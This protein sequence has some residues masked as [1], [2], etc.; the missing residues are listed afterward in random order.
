MRPRYLELEGLQSFREVQS[1][2]FDKLGEVGLFGIFGPTG[3]GK[4]TIL[5][6]LTLALYGNVQRA[7]RG[8]QGI[9]NMA[10]TMIRVSFTF[11]LV[12]EKI[13][14]TYKVERQYKRKKDSDSSIESK[15]ARLIEVNPAGD[16][17]LADKLGDVNE[18][19]VELIGL[20]F[21]DFTRSVVLPQNKFQ[22]FLLSP[23]GDKTKMLERIFYLEEYGRDLTEKV[24]RKLYRLRNKLS[25]IE[26]ALSML[27]EI[28]E[29]SLR[30][31]KHSVE[32]AA[33][34]KMKVDEALKSSE[35]E[36]GE[37]KEVWE[38]TAERQEAEVKLEGLLER[39]PEMESL[40]SKH[41]SALAAQSLGDRISDLEK[42][43]A[44]L[45]ATEQELQQLMQTLEG[46]R[47]QLEKSE[48]ELK[49]AKAERQERVPK[50]IE[51]RTKL[52]KA[53]ETKRELE[54]MEK[55]LQRLRAEYVMIKRQVDQWEEQIAGYKSR[56]EESLKASET[57]KL[58][59]T[60]L[61]V[62]TGYRDKVQKA[63]VL[64]EE[65]IRA[66][67]TI[68]QQ[69]ARFN[70]LSADIGNQEQ[71]LSK[72][73]GA[74]RGLYEAL[75][76]AGAAY[77]EHKASNR[78]D[79]NDILKAETRYYGIKAVTDSMRQKRKDV[80]L[81][82]A[83]MPDYDRQL[84]SLKKKLEELE[85]K[86]AGKQSELDRA[87]LFLEEKRRAAD[88]GSAAILAQSL[89][90]KEPCPVCGSTSHPSPA[91]HR[92]DED[93]N[94][95]QNSLKEAEASIGSL[96]S[97][98]RTLEREGIK[99][100][101]QHNNLTDQ[102]NQLEA[103]IK[104]KQQE[105]VE[106]SDRLPE[107]Y[108]EL[109]IALLE[110]K[111]DIMSGEKQE[112]LKGVE[113]WEAILAVL[114][115][116][117]RK[118]VEEYN[119]YKVE[120]SGKTSQVE[121]GRKHLEEQKNSCLA[122]EEEYTGKRR[123]Y[124]DIISAMG[125]KSAK[126]ELE[127]LKEDDLKAE[128][129]Y[130]RLQSDEK[131]ISELRREIE[132]SEEAN[133]LE[134]DKLS[135]NTAE[136]RGYKYRKEEK[137]KEIAELLGGLDIELERDKTDKALEALERSEQDA[138]EHLNIIREKYEKAVKDKTVQE[139]Q[140]EIYREKLG[141]DM[142]RLEKELALKGFADVDEVRQAY[143][144][145]D[146]LLEQEQAIKEYE[147]ALSNIK[148]HA[149]VVEKKLRGRSITEEHWAEINSRYQ[150][151][152]AEKESCIGL[153]ENAKSRYETIRVNYESWLSLNGEHKLHTRK[154][155]HLELFKNLL[156]GNGFIEYISEER[157]RYV[158]REASETLGTLTRHRYG[159][160][161]DTEN[162]FVIRDDSNG[163]M[164]RLVTTLSGGETFLTSLALALALSSQIQLKG[165]S[166]LEFFFLDEGFGTLDGT[167]L[168]T[169]IDSLERL[170]SSERVIGL[171][172]HVPEMKARITRRLIVEPP[173]AGGS[174]SK[175]YMEKA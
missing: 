25:G 148:A 150:A 71:E 166:P 164:R 97:E 39:A 26:G 137:E 105:S 77:E 7:N 102:K 33:E 149:G 63:A 158:A 27:G 128:E 52:T 62:E 89:K 37:A 30:E 101:E 131:S 44:E 51:H 28:S 22:E 64:E 165:Q 23:K 152:K 146:K 167:L 103:E 24:N 111:L 139:K 145:E 86:K 162:G 68:E 65:L 31:S 73:E 114:E 110:K 132:K 113:E 3:S 142:Q 29:D 79:R 43:E 38:L 118:A 127:R 170:S 104:I 125:V 88:C 172:S 20:Q 72:L 133:K 42:T 32:T 126:A 13:R 156:K 121:T 55:V 160:E 153:Y 84:S 159:L 49:H 95:L 17:V 12:R 108:R 5:D 135:E 169:V 67:H 157:L 168:D 40:K 70:E 21:D 171:I 144:P 16:I 107:D 45:R 151:L 19:V 120:S 2:D 94:A 138:Q 92:S 117:Q 41:K 100:T 155:E 1:V 115:E 81:L 59:I 50:L 75:D 82:E 53:L 106:L 83:K 143:L 61:K 98:F 85:A 76:K 18:A 175:V 11:D 54:D 134:Q 90:E 173:G 66:E 136:G 4:S 119:R 48:A 6:A 36:Y 141:E 8:T 78:W 93:I 60:A 9:I 174:G 147:E 124:T 109:S 57:R 74:G 140:R 14:K 35:A 163:G 47:S 91:V 116:K 161:L 34:Q 46:L 122:A 130:N 96:D 112:R 58:Q 129:L 154:K 80:E 10:S 87:K 69:K 15:L 123:K 56:L 99:L